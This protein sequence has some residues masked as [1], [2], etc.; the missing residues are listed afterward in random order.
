MGFLLFAYQKLSYKRRLNENNYRQ[1]LLSRH[2]LTVQSKISSI[3]QNKAQMQ[4]L[5]TM[6]TS[7]IQESA[8]STFTAQMQGNSLETAQLSKNYQEALKNNGNNKDAKEVIDA[9]TAMNDHRI[10]IEK[11]AKANYMEQMAL[12][13][14]LALSNSLFQ[15]VFEAA[16]KAQLTALHSEDQ[17]IEIEMANLKSEALLL[18]ANYDANEK[19][20]G[21]AAKDAAPSFGLG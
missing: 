3:E 17:R 13:Q 19:A 2:Q 6:A 20:E 14:G 16:D 15:S 8:N 9:Q 7:T 10:D 21:D 1:S 11:V 18:K 12:N 5:W 4:S